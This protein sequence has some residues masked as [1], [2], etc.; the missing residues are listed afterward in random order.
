[1]YLAF[2][3]LHGVRGC[4]SHFIAQFLFSSPEPH[5]IS[6]LQEAENSA[7]SILESTVCPFYRLRCSFP[8]GSCPPASSTWPFFCCSHAGLPNPHQQSGVGNGQLCVPGAVVSVLVTTSMFCTQGLCF[9]SG[10]ASPKA[11][12][13]LEGQTQQELWAGSYPPPVQWIPGCLGCAA[14]CFPPCSSI[15]VSLGCVCFSGSTSLPFRVHSLLSDISCGLDASY[16]AFPPLSAV[17]SSINNPVAFTCCYY[18]LFF[19]FNAVFFLIV[20]FPP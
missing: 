12:K 5:P 2:L 20:I 13:R 18:L 6:G 15:Q 11:A 1:M 14:S 10:T 7:I 19:L 9:V 16:Q 8:A 4:S 3:A 17:V